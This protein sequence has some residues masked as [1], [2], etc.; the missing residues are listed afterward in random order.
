[1]FSSC[2]KASSVELFSSVVIWTMSSF[3]L[4]NSSLSFIYWVEI[5]DYGIISSS[6]FYLVEW[7][8][9][10]VFLT[11]ILYKLSQVLQAVFE[12][13]KIIKFFMNQKGAQPKIMNYY[14]W[15]VKLYHNI[16]SS[17]SLRAEWGKFQ[18]NTL[19]TWIDA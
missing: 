13:L 12:P 15:S 4:W 10:T 14:V 1:M 5:L 11:R 19:K 3:W 9:E 7:T 6:F 8:L 17:L 2:Q 18:L 16:L